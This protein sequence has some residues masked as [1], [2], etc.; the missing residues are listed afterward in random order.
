M[1]WSPTAR[2]GLA[3]VGLILPSMR[4]KEGGSWA[5][6]LPFAVLPSTQEGSAVSR[7]DG[8][9]KGICSKAVPVRTIWA[10]PLSVHLGRQPARVPPPSAFLGS[11]Q[12][13]PMCCGVKLGRRWAGIAEELAPAIRGHPPCCPTAPS[14]P[15]AP[16]APVLPFTLTHPGAGL[17]SARRCFT[18][19]SW[20]PCP[21]LQDRRGGR[22][23]SCFSASVKIKCF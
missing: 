9:D 3:E 2:L 18:A 11:P 4:E 1:V 6:P 7:Q 16:C 21:A 17:H 12:W 5:G 19:P 22:W 20:C 10:F 8:V 13:D 15:A 23:G 14:V